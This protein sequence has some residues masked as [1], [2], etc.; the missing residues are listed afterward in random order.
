M[1]WAVSSLALEGPVLIVML[2]WLR[3]IEQR[4]VG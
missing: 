4:V 3:F 1:L 2:V